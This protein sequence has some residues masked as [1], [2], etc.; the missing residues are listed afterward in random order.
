M[1]TIDDIKDYLSGHGI[2]VQEYEQETATAATAAQAVGCSV[3]EI[4]KTILFIVGGTAV[5][6]VTCGDMKVKSSRLKQAFQLSG[7]VKLPQADDVYEY[8][9]YMPGGVCPFL[10]P[11]KL[12]ILLDQSLLRF[13]QT[14]AAA[15]NNHSAVPVTIAQLQIL[16]GA[17]FAD[18]C[19]PQ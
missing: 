3:A 7:K 17:E 1:P 11:E 19:D 18:V 14:Y 8:T 12:P 4:A 5:A 6:V 2:D 13:P 10:L 15:G 9:G 16:T